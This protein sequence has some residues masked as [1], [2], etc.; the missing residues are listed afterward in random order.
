MKKLIYVFILVTIYCFSYGKSVDVDQARQVADAYFSRYSGQVNPVLDNTFSAS[1]N[2]IITY[3]VYNYKGGGF[4][5]VSADDAVFPVLAQSNEGFIEKE[6]TNPA[7]KYWFESYSKEI[8]QII[9]NKLDN[10][11][12]SA[13]WR[14]VAQPTFSDSPNFD[15]VPLITTSWDQGAY[16]NYYC[17][18]AAGGPSGKC[19]TGCVATAMGQIMRFY[20]F[21]SKGVLSHSYTLSSYGAQSADFGN[22]TYDFA[23]MNASATAL[24]YQQIARLLYHAGVAVNMDYSPS[25]SGAQTS[26]VPWA[27]TNY[28]NYDPST[29]RLAAK[30]SYSTTDWKNLIIT[31]LNEHRPVYY[32]GAS[33]S[34]G[35]A[36]VCDGYRSSDDKFHMNWGWSGAQNGYFTIGALNTSSG[37]FN[38]DNQIVCGIQPGNPNLVVR[39]TNI[40]K[41]EILA[42]GKT[43]QI[44]YSVLAG[45]ATSLKLF[46]DGVPVN[47]SALQNSTYFWDTKSAGLGS[48]TIRAEA[49]DGANTV[50]QQL[51]VSLSEWV[52]QASG[53]STTGRGINNLHVVDSLVVW[54]SA[55]DGINTSSPINEFTKTTNGGATWTSGQ[56]KGG[57]TYG[58]GNICALNDKIAYVTLYNGVA[59]Q[60]N[61]CG[62]YKTSNGGNSWTQLTGALQGSASFAD[63]VWFWNE[64]EGMC[65]GDV[66]DGY[67]EIYYTRNGGSSWNRV[68]KSSIGN[69]ASPLTGEAGWTGVITTLGDST[70][71]FGSNK[72]K[73]YI[74]NDRGVTWRIS[75]TGITPTTNGGINQLAFRDKLHG[76]AVQTDG[77]SPVIKSTSDGG[78]T[79]QTLNPAGLFLTYDLAY[80]PGTENTYVSS[81]AGSEHGISY[82]FDGGLTWELFSG[83]ENNQ[84][85]ALG[86][87][88]NRNGW[89]GSFSESSTSL[90]MY[91]YLGMLQ[92]ALL[93]NPVNNLSAISNNNVVDL[94]WSAP[95]TA[96]LS[97]NVYRN[98]SLIASTT[99]A[100]F[101]DNQAS[102]GMQNYCVSAVYSS[103]ESKKACINA[104]I[105][106]NISPTEEAAYR[107]F[108]NPASTMLTLISPVRFNEV[109]LVNDVGK[110]VYDNMQKGTNLQ[111]NVNTLAK[112]MYILQII[113]D[114]RIVAKKILVK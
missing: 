41:D 22:T 40:S 87:A 46:I 15:I 63:N 81:G 64:N 58:I 70:V 52:P 30:T 80:V 21:P 114:K 1:I 92:P 112:G 60:D 36:W 19:Y 27:L 89:A 67:F 84:F 49:T 83:T 72:G 88:N 108:P 107:V 100:Q 69:G 4:V 45:N 53:F 77:T 75:N 102:A 68:P 71:M 111:I 95:S 16:Y 61:S 98:D 9:S 42:Y 29:I 76:L 5:V 93:L 50:Y 79:W 59:N 66:K 55:F 110:T 13:E 65:H 97:F 96:P 99:S 51:S 106:L 2:G 37:A 101:T 57:T 86:F 62:V 104:W 26:D 47:T 94:T 3:H 109:K 35:H 78:A 105:T 39:L 17:P 14:K 82:S 48:H 11:E 20:N 113:S 56:V 43:A 7:A 6:I 33:S 73:L 54:A 85:L 31:E 25:G 34:V 103:G 38:L 18:V 90:G 44:K 8:A 28:F 91:N 12:T 10:T 24:S 32:S 74:S 23:S